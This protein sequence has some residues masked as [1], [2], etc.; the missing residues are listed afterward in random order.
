[1]YFKELCQFMHSEHSF[2]VIWQTTTPKWNIGDT[3]MDHHLHVPYVCSLKPS[4]VLHRGLVFKALSEELGVW[5]DLY[6]DVM[7][8]TPQPYHAFNGA[9]VDMIIDGKKE[10]V[11]SV[12]P[13]STDAT[14]SRAK[15]L[16]AMAANTE[17]DAEED[18]EEEELLDEDQLQG[19]G[20]LI[21][22]TLGDESMGLKLV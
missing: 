20:I 1:M 7:H 14:D 8:F 18:R 15:Q 9:L 17:I 10:P 3:V 22:T 2:K 16:P 6:H 4:M 13:Y 12:D 11:D 21:A 19:P 5:S